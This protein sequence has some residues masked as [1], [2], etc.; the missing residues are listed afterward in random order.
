MFWKMRLYLRRAIGSLYS[1]TPMLESRSVHMRPDAATTTT[2]VE[3]SVQKP[4]NMK[5]P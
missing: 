3:K 5:T 2:M 1:S 4:P